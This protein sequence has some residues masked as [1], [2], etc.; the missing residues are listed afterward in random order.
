[1]LSKRSK[2]GIVSEKEYGGIIRINYMSTTSKKTHTN[3]QEEKTAGQNEQCS[4][5]FIENSSDIF[6]LLNAEHIATYVS[7]SVSSVLG[8]TPE[9]IVGNHVFVLVHSN[10]LATMRQMLGEIGQ[11]PGK[12]L[13]A[14]YRLRCK[15]GAWQWFEGSVTNLLSVPGAG[16]IIANF[17]A[18]IK[19]KLV[20]DLHWSEVSPSGH[21][22][23]FYE[24]D[25][26]LLDAVSGFIG[27]GLAEGDV[28][29][30]VSTK[31]H[32]E[33]LEDRLKANG[34]LTASHM[35]GKYISLSAV[36]M[37]SKFMV[38]G[39][40][41]PE[42]F[43]EV[44]RNIIAQ[45][46]RGGRPVR[47]FGEMVALLW[48]EENQVAAI[49]LEELW[50]NLHTIAS[51]T[52]FCAYSMHSFAGETC[53]G[54]FN[55]ICK[56][57][58]LIIPGKSDISLGSPDE[59]FRTIAPLPQKANTLGAALAE[60]GRAEE[61]LFRLAAI[62]ESSDDAILSK[63]LNGRITSWNAAAERMYGYSAQEIVGQ[64][65]ALLFLPGRQDEFEQIMEHIY[66]GERIDHFETT[67]VRKDG[68]F[69][70]V[71][72]TVSPIK[73][74]KGSIIGASSIARNITEQKRLEA[75]AQRL[76][77]SN[78]IGVF[79][80]D[81]SGVFLDANDAFLDLLGYTRAELQAGK[82]ERDA[83]TPPEFHSL[84]QDAVTALQ[85]IGSSGTYEK[86]YLHKSGKRVP[87]LVAVTRIDQS[88][89]TCI[90]FVLDIS[91]RKELDKRKDEFI[92]MAS[93]ELKTP[94]TSLKGFLG[95]LQR[96][97]TMQGDEK[98]LHYLTRMDA[99]INKLIKLI[100]DLLDLSKMQT[101]QLIYREECFALD[102]L[103]Q[104]IVEN[105]QETTQTHH[106]QLEGQIHAEVFGDRDRIGQVL[107][108]LLNNAI[109]YSQQADTVLVRV[110]KDQN[111]VHISVQ[112]FGIGVAEEYQQQIFERFYQIADTEEQTYPGLGI[113]LY[114]SCEIIKRHGG[115]LWVES[116]K[117]HGAT[118]HFTL[119][120]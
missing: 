73:D 45:A 58:S 55:D 14:E 44:F 57:H 110:A 106:L 69:L 79:V 99:Q 88:T 18:T 17:R 3:P 12:S 30:V 86:E 111:R 93:H 74:S 84:S 41:D 83:I 47:V 62:V 29:I 53:R 35:Q 34:L 4:H 90:G 64:P 19:Q 6:V 78:L 117:G 20:P 59:L 94:V 32:Q 33:R 120:L 65:V 39:L 21:F 102:E 75:R 71:S 108:N 95:L 9:E 112:D 43:A 81:F 27:S 48:A 5:P 105:V 23:Q 10:N 26:F 15:D 51:F 77:D 49:Q 54:A 61:A 96:R 92:S 85:E 103:V 116:K 80:S 68:T 82:V 42:R 87:V 25:E 31:T 118:F 60:H 56:Q 67:R 24:S 13:S 63:D 98:T 66:R 46:A 115:K 2:D 28:C 100:N 38:D 97:L 101:G 7:P 89:N 104:E 76:F 91:E 70:T 72:I 37:L 8:Y 11:A 16:A 114:I 52:L 22:V 40:P 107:I 119:P 36:E 109:K 1:M 113:G 50:N